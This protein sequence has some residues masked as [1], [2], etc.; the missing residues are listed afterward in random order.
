MEEL[1]QLEA[2]ATLG[3]Y[4]LLA[5]AAHG[6][7]A[8]VWAARLRGSHGFQKVVAI[9]TILPA[10]S[11]DPRFERM[12]LDEAALASRIRHPHV[13]EILDLGEER[14]VLYLVM[15]WIDGETLATLLR[16]VAAPVPVAVASRMMM[17]ACA[18]LH[19][20]HEL[21]DEQ[22][23]SL[24]LVHRDV[25]PQNLLVTREGAIK[26]VDFGV[27]K[28]LGRGAAETAVGQVKGKVPYMAPEQA[29]AGSIDRRAD[30]FALGTVYY[31]LVTGHHPFRA[32]GEGETLRNVI[33]ATPR[34]PRE[35]EP[36]LPPEIEEV[37]LT[38][39]ARDP[40]RRF[41]SMAAFETAIA[42][43][44][45]RL[46]M[47]VNDQAVKEYLRAAL[48]N[49]SEARR[50]WLDA[51][52][53]A[54]D[55]QRTATTPSGAGSAYAVGSMTRATGDATSVTAPTGEDSSVSVGADVGPS[56]PRRRRLGAGQAA[57]LALLS[58]GGLA[59]G[60]WCVGQ[61]APAPAAS[62]LAAASSPPAPS[63]SPTSTQTSE[64]L[65]AAVDAAAGS[66]AASSSAPA[67]LVAPPHTAPAA[68]D[69][70]RPQARPQAGAP[71]ST[72]TSTASAAPTTVPP[73]TSTK[74]GVEF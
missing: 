3:R 69:R 6:G 8:E 14:E 38:A 2:G 54:A 53:R 17:Q 48:G 5:R 13:V 67:S 62:E 32:D 50:D 73:P 71:S 47:M 20:A 26:V 57:M 72:A 4:E 44:L 1:G 7:M 74:A 37:I 29:L 22:G 40:E 34:R 68:P 24:D 65:P 46:G 23:R 21:C 63:A 25:S 15:E 70:P 59:A 42:A 12:F 45:G 41:A 43:A 33:A 52:L 60:W 11:D 49:R 61:G 51:A 9:K 10:L 16:K 30:V 56:P 27:A 39:L 18:G 64:A 28:A 35:V 31:F 36:S 55:R 58:A 66:V 19:A